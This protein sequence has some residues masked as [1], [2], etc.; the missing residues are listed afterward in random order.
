MKRLLVT[1][2][3]LLNDFDAWEATSL[4]KIKQNESHSQEHSIAFYLEAKDIILQG[5]NILVELRRQ[6]E[7]ALASAEHFI[8]N[9]A[10]SYH[11]AQCMAVI[12]SVVQI[13]E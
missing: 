6:E 2:D 9:L 10:I 12:N 3:S 5:N 7:K 4:S 11:E 13:Y 1:D 8:N